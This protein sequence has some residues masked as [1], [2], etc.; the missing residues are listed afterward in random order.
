MRVNSHMNYISYM[1]KRLNHMESRRLL[2]WKASPGESSD[3][4][5]MQRSHVFVGVAVI[6][7]LPHRF[8]FSAWCLSCSLARCAPTTRLLTL[9][10]VVG[11]ML[12]KDLLRD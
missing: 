9:L 6:S 2:S 4:A 1:L 3:M 10:I 8:S 12:D 7:R 5:S 11:H